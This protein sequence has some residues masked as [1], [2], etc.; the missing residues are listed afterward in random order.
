MHITTYGRVISSGD[1]ELP[2]TARIEKYQAG[3]LTDLERFPEKLSS[4]SIGECFSTQEKAKAA[5][6][7]VLDRISEDQFGASFKSFILEENDTGI[8]VNN[9]DGLSHVF[10][11]GRIEFVFRGVQTRGPEGQVFNSMILCMK[12]FEQ[13]S[14]GQGKFTM[15]DHVRATPIIHAAQPFMDQIFSRRAGT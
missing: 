3:S 11:D 8:F 12:A 15:P 2:F 10:P 13:Q 4:S 7:R 6:A 1:S 5:A 9:T 14:R